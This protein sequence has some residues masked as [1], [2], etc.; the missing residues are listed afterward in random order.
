MMIYGKLTHFGCLVP[1]NVSIVLYLVDTISLQ[2]A[3]H[4]LKN[5][6]H[7]FRVLFAHNLIS[8]TLNSIFNI[9]SISSRVQ[10]IRIKRLLLEIL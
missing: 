8:V 10:A 6:L 7:Y 9:N 5:C 4:Q 1:N 3:N 2:S